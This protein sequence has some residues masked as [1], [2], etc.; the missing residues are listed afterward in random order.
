MEL[1]DKK[2]IVF[3]NAALSLTR[4]LFLGLNLKLGLS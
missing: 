1:H 2:R 3:E 4:P